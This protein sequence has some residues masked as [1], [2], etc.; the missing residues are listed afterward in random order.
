MAK[1]SPYNPSS[2]RTDV[3]SRLYQVRIDLNVFDRARCDLWSRFLY[4]LADLADGILVSYTVDRFECTRPR[5]QVPD[6]AVSILKWESTIWPV[7]FHS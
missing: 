1:L 7:N 2:A 5:H 3:C 6:L 4:S